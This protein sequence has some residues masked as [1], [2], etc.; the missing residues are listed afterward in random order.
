M[1][2]LAILVTALCCAFLHLSGG[3]CA[4]TAV[5]STVQMNAGDFDR[6][7]Y[8]LNCKQLTQY[9]AGMRVIDGPAP[10]HAFSYG[11]AKAQALQVHVPVPAKGP[12]PVIVMVHGG[13][14]CFGDK[15]AAG[16]TANKVERW[17]SRGFVFVSVNY[18][19]LP[20]GADVLTQAGDVATAIAYVQAHAGEWG[21][22]PS[23]IVLM[24]HSAGAHLVSLVGTDPAFAARYGARPWLGTVSLD[25]A[26]LN[27]APEMR[28]STRPVFYDDVFGK[29]PAYWD[30]VSP[31]MHLSRASLPWLGVCSTQR[32]NSCRQA[33]G[34][35][36]AARRL[37]L[38]AEVLEVNLNHGEINKNL[39][40]PGD[41]TATVET[42]LKTL[43]PKVAQRL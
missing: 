43:S 8:Q 18:R 40:Q 37:G 11:P 20:D 27:V 10:A 15:N 12:A 6:A 42:F 32:D 4:Q 22:D 21:G 34:F 1:I 24:G 26:M 36:N 35:A 28:V 31:F 19:M 14:W 7:V 3:A 41:Y 5:P 9:V 25:T 17:V 13:A 39:G 2:R 23:A 38:S 29:A 16:V 33:H 30:K